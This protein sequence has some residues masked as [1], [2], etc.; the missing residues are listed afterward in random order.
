[1]V[2][3]VRS[4]RNVVDVDGKLVLQGEAVNARRAM[5]VRV[6]V[7]H[8]DRP[9]LRFRLVSFPRFRAHHTGAI[10]R[11]IDPAFDAI[12][13]LGLHWERDGD[14]DAVLVREHFKLLVVADEVDDVALIDHAD[15][16]HYP[17]VSVAHHIGGDR[18]IAHAGVAEKRKCPLKKE[19]D[20]VSC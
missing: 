4:D 1:M 19:A 15:I 17:L 2:S 16:G 13:R 14:F 5:R 12:P 7:W 3:F 10:R 6:L 9:V 8:L 20:R 11:D 18:V